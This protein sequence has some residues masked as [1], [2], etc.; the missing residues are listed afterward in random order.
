M[1]LTE[2]CLD[3]DFSG[4]SSL[5]RKFKPTMQTPAVSQV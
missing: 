3:T 5:H 2:A 4:L 1:T